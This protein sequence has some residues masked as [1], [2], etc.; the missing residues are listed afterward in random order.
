MALQSRTSKSSSPAIRLSSMATELQQNQCQFPNHT[1]RIAGGLDELTHGMEC[2]D[3]TPQ[4]IRLGN[5]VCRI[6]H[7]LNNIL[8]ALLGHTELA[9]LNRSHDDPSQRHL[10]KALL[11]GHRGKELLEQ[12]LTF[13]RGD[14]QTL[15]SFELGNIVDEALILFQKELPTTITIKKNDH[16]HSGKIF[17]NQTQIYQVVANLIS[18]AVKA[19]KTQGGS[20]HIDIDEINRGDLPAT[21][22]IPQE[23]Q[24]FLCL[25]ITDTG[26]GMTKDILDRIFDPY[27]TTHPHGEGTGLGLVIAK[28]VMT[29]HDGFISVES[30]P[31]KGTTFSV[32]F[33][34]F[35]E[36][37]SDNLELIR[38]ETCH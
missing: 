25:S 15:H 20:L 7:D 30:E 23:P 26:P 1:Q 13:Q 19:M 21:A 33:P 8:T 37:D 4:S 29:N 10:Q 3:H 9:T 32:Y 2:G 22:F 27:F 11:A 38:Q 5:M 16:S 34:T 24:H 6:A 35:R 12:I 18:N 28:E 14:Q 36:S 17:G 31:G